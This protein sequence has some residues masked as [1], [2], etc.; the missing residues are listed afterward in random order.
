MKKASAPTL[1]VET[2][3]KFVNAVYQGE[4]RV[5][6]VAFYHPRTLRGSS[7]LSAAYL[8]SILYGCRLHGRAQERAIYMD[9]EF[10]GLAASVWLG[11]GLLISVAIGLLV[12]LR[13]HDMNVGLNV[14]TGVLALLS[15]LQGIL[16]LGM[17]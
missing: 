7:Q 6:S 1:D 13:M 3:L 17:K 12:G 11:F 8:Q 2:G 9:T 14:G 10:D 5:L 16:I 15:T 4:D